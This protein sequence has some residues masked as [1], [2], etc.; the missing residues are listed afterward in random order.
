MTGK[1]EGRE[2]EKFALKKYQYQQFDLSRLTLGTFFCCG[3]RR[4]IV[5]FFGLIVHRGLWCYI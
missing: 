3:F 4:I 1:V 5:Y 2:A